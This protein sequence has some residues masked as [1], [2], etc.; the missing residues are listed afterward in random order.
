MAIR[1][2]LDKIIWKPNFPHFYTFH[3]LEMDKHHEVVACPFPN[4]ESWKVG[5]FGKHA[6]AVATPLGNC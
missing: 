5:K 4:L 2:V 1:G 3:N 6:P